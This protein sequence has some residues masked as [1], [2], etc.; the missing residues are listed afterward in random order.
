MTTI[1]SK[2]VLSDFAL[3][4]GTVQQKF[5]KNFSKR[6][7]IVIFQELRFLGSL[8]YIQKANN[9]LKM[10]FAIEGFQLKK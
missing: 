10:N 9:R 8:R 6:M 2:G 4:L 1:S 7:E 3:Y 5:Y